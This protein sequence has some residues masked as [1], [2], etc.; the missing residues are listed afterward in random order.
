MSQEELAELM[1]GRTGSSLMRFE[2]VVIRLIEELYEN[3]RRW[4]AVQN[5]QRIQ[6]DA[7]GDRA[8]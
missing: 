3:L 2:K 7:G 6:R 4:E 1:S 5:S 8:A